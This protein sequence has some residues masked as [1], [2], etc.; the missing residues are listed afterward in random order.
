MGVLGEPQRAGGCFPS[1]AARG[2]PYAG[3]LAPCGSPGRAPGQG[4]W[5]RSRWR[6][7]GGGVW[8]PV[9]LIEGTWNVAGAHYYNYLSWTP[10]E[11]RWFGYVRVSVG[12]RR[13]QPGRAL[14]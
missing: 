11:Q 7:P 2:L 1:G 4:R 13:A 6:A 14:R 5:L 9:L 10:W 3:R 8:L 12:G